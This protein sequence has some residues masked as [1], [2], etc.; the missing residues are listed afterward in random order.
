MVVPL[1]IFNQLVAMEYVYYED[2]AMAAL[3]GQGEAPGPLRSPRLRPVYSW[4]SLLIDFIAWADGSPAA[5]RL[6]GTR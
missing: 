1:Q 6:S 5:N 3:A 2:E 4:Q